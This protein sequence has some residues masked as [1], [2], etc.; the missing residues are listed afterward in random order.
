M[1][2]WFLQNNFLLNC[3][4]SKLST[5]IVEE[6]INKVKESRG[7]YENLLKRFFIIE[8]L[9]SSSFKGDYFKTLVL[10]SNSKISKLINLCN[11]G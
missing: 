5:L 9:L 4:E 2:Q 1:E 7:T 10:T 6:L 11:P 8:T 3:N